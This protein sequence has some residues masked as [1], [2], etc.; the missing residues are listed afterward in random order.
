[1]QT[2]NMIPESRD[3]EGAGD[4]SLAHVRQR[5]AKTAPMARRGVGRCRLPAP[6]YPR[7]TGF[8]T[9]TYSIA[10]CCGVMPEPYSSAHTR[11]NS[12]P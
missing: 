10:P 7:C 8:S 12:A 2:P 4:D 9:S 1:M 3:E 11:V 5:P 6:G